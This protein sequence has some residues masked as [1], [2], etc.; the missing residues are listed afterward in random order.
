MDAF[1]RALLAAQEILDN[2]EYRQLLTERYASFDTADG[3][4]FE[5]GKLKLKDLRNIAVREGEPKQRSGR[6]ELFE[7][8]LSRHV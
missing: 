4:A 6:Q 8:L 2:S 3:K 7:N 1:A 5:S